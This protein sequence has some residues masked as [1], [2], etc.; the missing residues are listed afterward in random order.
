MLID[1]S[2]LLNWSTALWDTII[3]CQDL[4][5]EQKSNHLVT[6]RIWP[7]I[8]L[9]LKSTDWPSHKM[10]GLIDNC[11]TTLCFVY[12]AQ[13]WPIGKTLFALSGALTYLLWEKRLH[14]KEYFHPCDKDFLCGISYACSTYRWKMQLTPDDPSKRPPVCTASRSAF[15]FSVPPIL[16]DTPWHFKLSRLLPSIKQHKDLHP[17]KELYPPI[18][19]WLWIIHCR[20]F[21]DHFSIINQP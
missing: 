17:L 8:K 6:R 5:A 3:D 9:Y 7:T 11:L 1:E 21:F 12:L 2:Q 14:G 15:K 18:K 20:I 19:Q 16:Y 10:K 13:F 4:Y